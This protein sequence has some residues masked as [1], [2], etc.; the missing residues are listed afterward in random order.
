MEYTEKEKE[1]IKQSHVFC[2]NVDAALNFLE[3]IT[4]KTFIQ[5]CQIIASIQAVNLF[6]SCLTLVLIAMDR[7]LILWEIRKCN[8]CLDFC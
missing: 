5:A 8:L 4:F 3:F 6:V 2:I 7:F 1:G